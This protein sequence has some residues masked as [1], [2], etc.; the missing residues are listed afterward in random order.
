MLSVILANP[1]LNQR[2]QLRAQARPPFNALAGETPKLSIASRAPF[3]SDG[4]VAQ[5]TRSE[6]RV[7]GARW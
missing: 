5:L 7:S 1:A 6:S 3:L 4:V 2:A